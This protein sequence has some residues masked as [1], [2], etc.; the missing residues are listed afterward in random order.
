[1]IKTIIRIENDMVKV[2]DEHGIE[3]PEYQGDYNYVKDRIIADA[4]PDSVFNHWF[5]HSLK[6]HMCPVGVQ[7][8][9]PLL[10]KDRKNSYYRPCFHVHDFMKQ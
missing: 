3:I 2:F 5:G 10:N 9:P 1:M 7:A 8:I 6:P 4:P